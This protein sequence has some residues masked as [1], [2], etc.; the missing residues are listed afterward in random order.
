MVESIGV[1]WSSD[2]QAQRPAR[3]S[4]LHGSLGIELNMELS[5]LDERNAIEEE[6]GPQRLGGGGI[7]DDAYLRAI[8]EE[9]GP[10]ALAAAGSSTTPIS[11]PS[12]RSSGVRAPAPRRRRDRR[13]RLSPR[14]RGGVRSPA[15]WR[16]R[17]GLVPSFYN[18]TRVNR[19][20]LSV[21][22]GV[23]MAPGHYGGPRKPP[24][25]L[26]PTNVWRR[27]VP[28]ERVRRK[29]SGKLGR[30]AGF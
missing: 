11:A 1:R 17:G 21:E 8:E 19:T 14:H 20:N 4:S 28:C 10:S 6:F 25:M 7:V 9:F 2:S 27:I 22:S 5:D 13:R 15:P 24:R 29:G 18:L 12:R 26:S 30:K 3:S 16:R 23:T